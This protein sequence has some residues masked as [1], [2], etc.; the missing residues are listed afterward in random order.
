MAD[1]AHR[2]CPLPKKYLFPDYKLFL[3][4]GGIANIAFHD[5]EKIVAYDVCAANTLC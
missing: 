5:D 1:K 2:L 3:N 4:I